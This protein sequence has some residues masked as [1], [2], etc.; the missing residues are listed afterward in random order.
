[1]GDFESEWVN[2]R[3]L[4]DSWSYTIHKFTMTPR[5]P[6]PSAPSSPGIPAEGLQFGIGALS[7]ATGVPAPTLRTWER[8]YGFPVAARTAGGQRVYAAEMVDQVRLAARAMELGHRPAAVFR[9]SLDELRRLVDL[10]VTPTLPALP[11]L[12]G[13]TLETEFRRGLAGDGLWGLLQRRIVPLLS[14]VGDAWAAGRLSVYEEHLYSERL[15]EFL[16]SSWRPMADRNTGPVGLCATFPGEHHALGLHLAACALALEGW[17]V[18]F[19]GVDVPIDQIVMGAQSSGARAVFLSV[20]EGGRS[21]A[22]GL[23]APLRALLPESVALVLGGEGAPM[24]DQAVVLGTLDA[25]R[26]W[27]HDHG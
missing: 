25:L 7:E 8:R 23:V 20:S 26:Q 19:L 15:R 9:A 16:V 27:L 2:H 21:A 24:D 18:V 17:R 6:V 3:D 14:E 10:D 1:M 22:S 13:A 12:D 4:C 11:T 5:S